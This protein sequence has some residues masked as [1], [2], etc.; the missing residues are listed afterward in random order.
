MRIVTFFQPIV[1]FWKERGIVAAE[2]FKADETQYYELEVPNDH[3]DLR[4]PA[5]LQIMLNERMAYPEVLR[6]RFS[7]PL[8]VVMIHGQVAMTPNKDGKG[9][10]VPVSRNRELLHAAFTKPER[11]QV[12]VYKKLKTAHHVFRMM[13]KMRRGG[14]THVAYFV[15]EKMVEVLDLLTVM[16]ITKPKLVTIGEAQDAVI[17]SDEHL[18]EDG[19]DDNADDVV[20][21]D[22]ELQ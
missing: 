18:V 3:K 5:Y 15:G 1:D 21:G 7:P 9:F 16:M 10:A 19:A 11:Q 2:A 6:A 22:E 20:G 13:R 12:P 14:V 8:Y 17:G 4:D